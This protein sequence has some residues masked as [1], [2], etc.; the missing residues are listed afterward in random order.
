MQRKSRKV[1][2]FS[3]L[4]RCLGRVYSFHR[5]QRTHNDDM[6]DERDDMHDER[7]FETSPLIKELELQGWIWS[8]GDKFGRHLM[9]P[10]D[11]EAYICFDPFT[12]EALLSR[13]L[14][15]LLDKQLGIDKTS[16][17]PSQQL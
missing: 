5:E 14:Q 17:R 16:V 4:S 2:S 15:S 11:P 6:H 3:A 7:L 10:E 8:E 13:K 9:L 12:G 1:L